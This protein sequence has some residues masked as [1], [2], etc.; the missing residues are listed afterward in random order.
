MTQ[1]LRVAPAGSRYLGIDPGVTGA[2]ALV[3]HTAAGRS[4]LV[5]DTP[6]VEIKRGTRRH[7]DFNVAAMRHLLLDLSGDGSDCCA[8]IEAVHGWPGMDVKSVTSLLHGA[9]LWE[10]LCAGLGIPVFRIEPAAW[11]KYHGLLKTEKTASRVRAAERFPTAELGAKSKTGR[12]D[13]LLIA[14]YG[15]AMNF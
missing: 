7:H 1:P 4:F 6:V 10:G 13:A 12:A 15:R 3:Q 9:G 14:A 5:H 8:V 11:K 2:I